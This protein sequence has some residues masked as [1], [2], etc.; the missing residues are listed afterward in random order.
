MDLAYKQRQTLISRRAGSR[1]HNQN[2]LRSSSAGSLSG[3]GGGGGGASSLPWS[4]RRGVGGSA[5][6]LN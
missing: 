6:P 3:S 2:N 5:D 4:G 1:D